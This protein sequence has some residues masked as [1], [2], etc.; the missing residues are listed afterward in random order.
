MYF[1]FYLISTFL[2]KIYTCSFQRL[3]G[4]GLWIG[5][6]L[7]KNNPKSNKNIY[8]RLLITT[9]PHTLSVRP[10]GL[11]ALELKFGDWPRTGVVVR[12]IF[13]ITFT[14]KYWDKVRVGVRSTGGKGK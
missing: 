7:D 4:L 8:S 3:V 1:R 5:L 10:F 2:V 14:I 9:Y 13:S 12:I 11:L 6:D